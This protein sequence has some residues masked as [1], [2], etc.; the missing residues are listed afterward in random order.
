MKH[1]LKWLLLTFVVGLNSCIFPNFTSSSWESTLKHCR[2]GAFDIT[3]GEVELSIPDCINLMWSDGNIFYTFSSVYSCAYY[4][5]NGY[6]E[7]VWTSTGQECDNETRIKTTTFN[8]NDHYLNHLCQL[9]ALCHIDSALVLDGVS[10][11]TV[12][13]TACV[14]LD[15][16]VDLATGEKLSLVWESPEYNGISFL[17][18]E[19]K[20]MATCVRD[21]EFKRVYVRNEYQ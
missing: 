10:P 15:N 2:W 16:V 20:T 1:K 13:G 9:D 11:S 6:G 21:P 12:I 3:F 18:L 8:T 19:F 7:F 17:M 5:Y 4:T 14:K